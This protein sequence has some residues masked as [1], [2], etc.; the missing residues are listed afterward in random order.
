M[1][2]NAIFI[3]LG[4]SFGAAKAFR[5]YSGQL[6]FNQSRSSKVK[7]TIIANICLIPSWL[8]LIFEN[9]TSNLVP[10]GIQ[11][12]LIF[13]V[14]YSVVF[15]VVMGVLPKHIFAKLNYINEQNM[16]VVSSHSIE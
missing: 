13:S 6:W 14:Y 8:L 2:S 5:D 12:Y 7:M 9:L 1:N 16:S 4:A 11:T 10:S 3:L 15:Y